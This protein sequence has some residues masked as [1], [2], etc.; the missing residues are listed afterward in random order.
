MVVP[1][2]FILLFFFEKLESFPPH[3][4]NYYN[5]YDTELWIDISKSCWERIY[6]N[7]EFYYFVCAKRRNKIVSLST[8]VVALS[9]I[10]F[11]YLFLIVALYVNCWLPSMCTKVGFKYNYLHIPR[12]NLQFWQHCICSTANLIFFLFTFWKCK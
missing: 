6:V 1:I 3:L 5:I 11:F 9:A 2:S 8:N 10:N 4:T 12:I 7:I